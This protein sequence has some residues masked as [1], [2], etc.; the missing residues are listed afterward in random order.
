LVV[1]WPTPDEVVVGAGPYGNQTYWRVSISQQQ[2]TPTT[3][4]TRKPSAEVIEEMSQISDRV[5]ET[6]WGL[7]V[8]PDGRWVTWGLTYTVWFKELGTDNPP[9][10]LIASDTPYHYVDTRKNFFAWSWQSDQIAYNMGGFLSGFQI[11]IDN[12]NTQQRFIM[13]LTVSQ[14]SHLTWSPDGNYLVFIMQAEPRSGIKNMYLIEVGKPDFTPL[15]THGQV[16]NIISWSPAGDAII[17]THWD[18]L[19]PWLVTLRQKSED[20]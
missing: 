7:Q 16:N 2:A 20:Q 1:D 10:D 8:S 17:Y 3:W 4:E 5:R 15:L 11:Q 14:P 18:K 6:D 9:R 13:P 19:K 12:L